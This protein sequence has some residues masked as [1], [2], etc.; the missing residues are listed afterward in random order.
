MVNIQVDRPIF[1]VIQVLLNTKKIKA[2][3][4]MWPFLGLNNIQMTPSR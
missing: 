1:G 3:N 2:G 4:Q